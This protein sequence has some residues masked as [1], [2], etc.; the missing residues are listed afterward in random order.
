MVQRND[1]GSIIVEGSQDHFDASGHLGAGRIER[2]RAVTQAAPVRGIPC[3]GVGVGRPAI[4]KQ[5]GQ[6]QQLVTS[7]Y[8]SGPVR[9][10][11]Q[12]QRR[13]AMPEA[14][15]LRAFATRLKRENLLADAEGL[16]TL[17]ATA[18]APIASRSPLLSN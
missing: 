9:L 3:L 14:P 18:L 5:R 10:G 4:V 16:Q 2:F 15:Q 8:G 12:Y 13:A 6:Q 11:V 7:R 1:A 17:Y